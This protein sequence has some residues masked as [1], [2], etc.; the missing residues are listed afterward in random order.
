MPQPRFGDIR[1]F[2]EVDGWEETTK[3]AGGKRRDHF[4]YR[5]VL[6]DGTILRTRASMGNDEI[7]DPTLWRHIWRDQLGLE[8]EDQFW[9]ALRTGKS[10]EREPAS[11]AKPPTAAAEKKDARLYRA[12]IDIAGLPE[13]E[14]RSMSNEEMLR[15]WMAYVEGGG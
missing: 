8:S 1:R 3:K 6:D 11:E 7:G 10:V 15:R 13:A 2:C 14:V 9:E 4:R 5:K 12:L